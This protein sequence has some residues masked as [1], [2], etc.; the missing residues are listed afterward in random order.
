MAK[1]REV[2]LG[3]FSVNEQGCELQARIGFS[4][5]MFEDDA[6]VEHV[7]GIDFSMTKSQL[8]DLAVKSITIDLQKILRGLGTHAKAREFCGQV[9]GYKDV[10]PGVRRV[11]SVTKDMSPAEV[12]AR[13]KNDPAYRAALMAELEAMEDEDMADKIGSSTMYNADGDEVEKSAA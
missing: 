6:S 1:K 7:A 5:K 3:K 10:Y 11:V 4:L 9:L 2:T 13:C 12:K 8:I